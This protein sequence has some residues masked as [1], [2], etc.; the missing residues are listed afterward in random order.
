MVAAAYGAFT[1]FQ[2]LTYQL[3]GPLPGHHFIQST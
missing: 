1:I 2:A 3:L